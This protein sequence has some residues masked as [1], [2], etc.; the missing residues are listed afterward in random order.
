[1]TDVRLID[2]N[3]WDTSKD[4]VLSL[5]EIEMIERSRLGEVIHGESPDHFRVKTSSL[6]GVVVGEG[7]ELRVRPHLSVPRLMFLLGYARDEHGWKDLVA[8]FEEEDDLF[9][10]IATSFSYHATWALDRGVLRGYLHR[11]ERSISLRGRVRFG[12]QIARSG[13]LPLPVELSWDDF[14]EDVLENRML[15]TAASV[16]L[17]LPRIPDAT[18][19]R[20]LRLRA[21]LAEITELPIGVRP[22]TPRITRLNDRYAPALTL[23]ELVLRA[24]STG[25][26]REETKGTT[27][28]FDMNKVFEEFVSTALAESL[29]RRNHGGELHEQVTDVSLSEKIRLKPDLVWQR[30]GGWAAVLDVKYKRLASESFPNADAFQMLAYSLAYGLPEGRLVYAKMPGQ[31]PRV[32]MIPSAGKRI[33][34]DCINVALE[35]EEVLAEVDEL[36]DRM[37]FAAADRVQAAA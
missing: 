17:R 31:E 13:G 18:R 19:R 21:I 35:P 14:T 37:A 7:W 32:H 30:N 15:R 34:V 33:V 12:D 25:A 1:V 11:D 10:A 3:A 24:A 22:K 36:A 26:E 23:A 20:L 2:V 5:D 28:V 6:I 27:F 16:L 29:R 9:T 8:E 4:E